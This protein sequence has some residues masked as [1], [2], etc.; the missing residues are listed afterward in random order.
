MLFT[1]QFWDFI[2]VYFYVIVIILAILAFIV[3]KKGC[4]HE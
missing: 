3:K 4:T 2:S 1:S